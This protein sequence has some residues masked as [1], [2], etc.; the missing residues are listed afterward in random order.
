[1]VNMNEENSLWIRLKKEEST[2]YKKRK[3]CKI[4]KTNQNQKWY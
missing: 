4:C 3:K 1:M 2:Y